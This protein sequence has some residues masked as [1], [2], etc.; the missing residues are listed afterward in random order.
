MLE[1]INMKCLGCYQSTRKWR[2]S[3]YSSWDLS[4]CKVSS[5]ADSSPFLSFSGGNGPYRSE[6]GASSLGYSLSVP[7]A[8]RCKF[9]TNWFGFG[10]MHKTSWEL[11][12]K[13]SQHVKIGRPIVESPGGLAVKDPALLLLWYKTYQ[14]HV[15]SYQVLQRVRF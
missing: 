5:I 8:C 7:A 1:K 2:F 3:G 15:H 9:T 14:A 4:S 6:V 13:L 10:L 12:A 11:S